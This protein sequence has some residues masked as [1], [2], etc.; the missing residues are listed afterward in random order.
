ML[1]NGIHHGAN[2]PGSVPAMEA[3]DGIAGADARLGQPFPL[4]AEAL[5]L[6]RWVQ[7]RTV[8]DGAEV[9]WNLDDSRGATPGRLALY[10]GTV[11]PP[12]QLTGQ[13]QR[14]T[15]QDGWTISRSALGEAEPSLRPVVQ[16]TWRHDALHLRLTAQGPWDLTRVLTIARSVG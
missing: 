11:A 14:T 7:V 3:L 12:E 10:A 9:E 1:L 6:T 5:P 16:V 13:V 4:P 8:G 15:T 2:L